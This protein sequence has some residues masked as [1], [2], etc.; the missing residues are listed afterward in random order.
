M[1]DRIEQIRKKKKMTAKQLSQSTNIPESTY[2]TWKKYKGN[3]KTK[4]VPGIAKALGVSEKYILTG[5][6][7]DIIDE[8]MISVNKRPELIDLFAAAKK[9]NKQQIEQIIKMIEAFN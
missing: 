3:P 5:E 6:E 7:L 9:A 8:I 4:D 1:I 2:S